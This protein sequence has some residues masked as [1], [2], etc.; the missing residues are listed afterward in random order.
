MTLGE[1]WAVKSMHRRDLLIGAIATA[2][3][4]TTAQAELRCSAWNTNAWRR[5]YVGVPVPRRIAQ[6]RC[7][8][9]CWAACIEAVFALNGYQVAQ[10]T[11]VAKVFPK[12]Q[13]KTTSAHGIVT[14][15]N[16]RWSRS[17]GDSFVANADVLIDAHDF[18]QQPSAIPKAAHEL[19]AGRPLIIGTFGHATVLTGM[20]YML[21]TKGKYVVEQLIV[22]DP[23]PD[24]PSRRTLTRDE[25]REATFLA[26]VTTSK[27]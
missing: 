27:A 14:A 12:L 19:A 26:K 22:R 20:T 21:N 10:E 2:L 1:V 9:W 24:S 7:P 15:I 11:I 3:S 23:W 13:C 17:D 4:A 6:Q 18:L 25:Q 8:N 16:G 5:C